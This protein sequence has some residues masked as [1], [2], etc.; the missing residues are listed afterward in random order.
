[1]VSLVPLTEDH[2][3]ADAGASDGPL[4]PLPLLLRRP[5]LV[6]ADDADAGVAATSADAIGC[7][8]EGPDASDAAAAELPQLW[9]AWLLWIYDYSKWVGKNIPEANLTAV[10]SG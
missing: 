1:M 5:P 3:D 10:A 8:A 2:E 6:A 4:L 7:A 9:P